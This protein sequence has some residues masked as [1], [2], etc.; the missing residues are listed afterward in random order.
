MR[1]IIHTI[2]GS[3]QHLI[4]DFSIG[5]RYVHRS[6]RETRSTDISSEEGRGFA[7]ALLKNYKM[8]RGHVP[9]SKLIKILEI[10]LLSINSQE[11]KPETNHIQTHTVFIWN[12]IWT[13]DL[14]FSN[15]GTGTDL[16]SVPDLAL[17]LDL[18]P[19]RNPALEP[20]IDETKP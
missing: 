9:V 8:S 4:Y 16:N 5:Y 1:L 11:T 15:T 18:D 20:A 6:V 7:C 2:S 3:D 10:L 19:S 14:D 13:L 17:V 12:C